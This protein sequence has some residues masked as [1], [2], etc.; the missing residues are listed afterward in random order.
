[1]LNQSSVSVA[2]RVPMATFDPNNGNLKSKCKMFKTEI[3]CYLS[4]S[5]YVFMHLYITYTIQC[6]CIIQT[7]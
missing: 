4:N 7:R 1:M 6:T 3:L 2:Q 5:I